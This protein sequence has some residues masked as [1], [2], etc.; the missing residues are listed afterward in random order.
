[1][2]PSSD[3]EA[4][5][6]V[7][8]YY[9]TLESRLGYRLVL[10]GTRH[11]GYYDVDTYWPFPIDGALR[12]MEDRLFDSLGLKSGAKVL[13]A[14]CG[15]GH[16]AINMARRG[17]RVQGIDV[18][19]HHIQKAQRNIKRRGL[20]G[21][22]AFRKMDYHHLDGFED[23][24]FDGVYT[25]ET[26]VHA[27]D[28]EAAAREFFR[29]LKPGG[30]IALHEYDHVDLNVVPDGAKIAMEQ[31]NKY[32]AMPALD[33]FGPG[34]IQR[35]LEEVGFQEVVVEDLTINVTPMLRLFFILA[36]IPYLFVRL[37][38]L[39]AWFVNT[40]AG[41]EGYR[42]RHLGRYV[43]VSGRKPSDSR[44]GNNIQ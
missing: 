3:Q 28:P 30:S 7:Q 23:E 40:M 32:A 34:V 15:V 11:F 44:L 22:V 26:F 38:H 36:Y 10:G 29:V 12:A 37:F 2:M 19:N 17:L 21:S 33:R 16:V 5:I 24:S 6:A 27:R 8:N 42:K 14:G 18:V 39:E 31:V 43:A 20:D 1:M 35:I 25:M 13:D 9:S 41:V 4:L